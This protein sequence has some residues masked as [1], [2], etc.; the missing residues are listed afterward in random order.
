MFYDMYSIK[1]RF[2]QKQLKGLTIP[3]NFALIDFQTI[4]N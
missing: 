2:F 4:M 3:K 1:L